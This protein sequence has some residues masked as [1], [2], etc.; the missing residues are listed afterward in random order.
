MLGVLPLAALAACS[1]MMA[2][3]ATKKARRNAPPRASS[4]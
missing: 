2:D 3:N 4:S 1:G